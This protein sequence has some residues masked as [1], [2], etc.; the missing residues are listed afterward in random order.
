MEGTK[1]KVV[2]YKP[3]KKQ[4]G[5]ISRDFRGGKSFRNGKS[6]FGGNW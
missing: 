6:G 1:S 5:M 4:K 2:I 3:Q